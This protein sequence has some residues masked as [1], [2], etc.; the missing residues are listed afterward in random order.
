MPMTHIS[1]LSSPPQHI[2]K[3]IDDPPSIT[4]VIN[5]QDTPQ[6]HQYE[7]IPEYLL[8]MTRQ[9]HSTSICHHGQQFYGSGPYSNF[10]R[11][12]LTPQEA[13]RNT[14]DCSQCTCSSQ[15]S[16][17]INQ[18][19]SSTPLLTENLSK[20]SHTRDDWTKTSLFS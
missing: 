15:P 20:E 17:N 13:T 2:S 1:S 14:S 19:E 8:T 18:E 7:C 6:H 16:T 5:D 11:L 9:Q 3:S 4:N 12:Y 10:S